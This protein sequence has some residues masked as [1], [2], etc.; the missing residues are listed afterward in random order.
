MI[1]DLPDYDL[2][3]IILRLDSKPGPKKKDALPVFYITAH[4]AETLSILSKTKYMPN[5]YDERE[6]Y[7]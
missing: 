5:K 6:R 2:I 3:I 1:N 7:G 4:I